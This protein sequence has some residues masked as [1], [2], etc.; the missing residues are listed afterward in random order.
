MAITPGKTSPI[1]ASL[2]RP[3]ARQLAA[4]RGR[5]LDDLRIPGVLHAAFFRSPYPHARL[6]KLDLEAAR[7]SPGVTA[8]YCADDI[9]KVMS[10]WT[11]RMPSLASHRSVTQGPLVAERAL[12][13]GQ[14]VAIVIAEDVALAEDAA[15]SIAADGEPVPALSGAERALGA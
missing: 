1:G 10:G 5:F 11:A 13:Q 15:A 7:A 9:A 4:G 2:P 12:W 3:K 8:V 6:L 14:P